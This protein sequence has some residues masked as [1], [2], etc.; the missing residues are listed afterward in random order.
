MYS[1]GM[2]PA[3]SIV[4]QRLHKISSNFYIVQQFIKL[5]KKVNKRLM[6]EK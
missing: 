5:S 1:T 4:K 3:H 6:V 2:Y